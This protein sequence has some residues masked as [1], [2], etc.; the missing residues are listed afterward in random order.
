MGRWP[1][2]AGKIG[3]FTQTLAGSDLGCAAIWRQSCMMEVL[4]K[5][6]IVRTQA[7]Q[8]K[9]VMWLLQTTDVRSLGRSN[10]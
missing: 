7:P 9:A 4:E 10:W 2:D 5:D 8:L 1:V 3:L 6:A